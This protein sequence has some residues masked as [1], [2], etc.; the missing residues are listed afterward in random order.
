MGATECRAPHRPDAGY[1]ARRAGCWEPAGDAGAE[2][3]P[4]V[5]QAARAARNPR[6]LPRGRARL[7]RLTGFCAGAGSPPPL[8]GVASAAVSAR[9]LLPSPPYGCA[10]LRL[11]R[12]VG[13]RWV[14]AW[15]RQGG[16][17]ALRGSA[18]AW[19][20]RPFLRTV[21]CASRLVQSTGRLWFSVGAAVAV[22]WAEGPAAVCGD[23]VSPQTL[24]SHLGKVSRT[25]GDKQP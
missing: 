22:L 7:G 25:P 10:R 2:P 1:I 23:A 15:W 5:M 3:S 4:P 14:A 20:G 12:A 24:R 19:Q 13:R 17:R 6:P 21:P 8:W 11:R 16:P 9:S 18:L